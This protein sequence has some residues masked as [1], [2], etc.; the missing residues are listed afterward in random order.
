MQPFVPR[1][2][3]IIHIPRHVRMF[4]PLI[5]GGLASLTFVPLSGPIVMC[6]HLISGSSIFVVAGVLAPIS[7]LAGSV[8]WAATIKKTKDVNPWKVQPAQLPLRI[9]VSAAR[10]LYYARVV[11]GLLMACST[12]PIIWSVSFFHPIP[13]TPSPDYLCFNVALYFC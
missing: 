1:L 11:S 10:G 3:P 9:E 8:T 2:L 12:I 5:F 7:F 4:R 6:V 13:T